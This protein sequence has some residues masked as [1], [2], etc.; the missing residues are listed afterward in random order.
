MDKTKTNLLQLFLKNS[1]LGPFSFKCAFQC[2]L[3]NRNSLVFLFFL[4]FLIAFLWGCD[5]CEFR[6]NR[7]SCILL[8]SSSSS[9]SSS[10]SSSSSSSR[11]LGR[12]GILT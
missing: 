4:V 2:C 8:G 5:C 11:S 3:G 1:I 6:L 10:R 7:G 9:S 12:L